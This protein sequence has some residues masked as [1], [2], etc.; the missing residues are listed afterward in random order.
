M[1]TPSTGVHTLRSSATGN[2]GEVDAEGAR[3]C[4]LLGELLERFG[5]EYAAL[6]TRRGALDFDDLELGA[7]TLLEEHESVRRAWAER[8]ELMM[9]DE[10]QDTNPR[11]LAILGALERGNLFTVGDELQSIYGF[12]HAD[13]SLFRAR[14]DELAEHGGSLS[15]TRN[16]RGRKPLLDV[17]NV[18]FGERFGDRYTPLEA[19]RADRATPAGDRPHRSHA[20]ADDAGSRED[21]RAEEEQEP[22]VE[23]LLTHKRVGRRTRIWPRASPASSRRPRAGVRPKRGCW[24]GASRSSCRAGPRR[25]ETWRC[26]CARSATWSCTSGHFRTAA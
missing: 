1:D 12:R 9:V 18:V 8:F 2:P 7:C 6:K 23:L 22:I 26:C 10:F 17:V 13:V 25:R 16:F 11:Q 15:L 5:H 20:S 14:R 21:A 4:A 24:P 3:A 19:G